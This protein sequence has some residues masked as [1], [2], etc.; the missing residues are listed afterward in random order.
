MYCLG[1]CV[2]VCVAV[3]RGQLQFRHIG[4]LS[5]VCQWRWGGG[6]DFRRDARKF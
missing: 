4:L 5:E 2:C 3:G 6:A 1:V